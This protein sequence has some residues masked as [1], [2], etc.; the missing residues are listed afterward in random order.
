MIRLVASYWKFF[1]RGIGLKTVLSYGPPSA[2]AWV[3]FA[4]YL[5]LLDHGNSEAFWPTL[6]LGL[7]AIAIGSSIV[8]WLV[9]TI[10][11]PL[12]KITEATHPS[13]GEGRHLL[14]GP[15]LPAA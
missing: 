13:P 8:L 15:L 7:A 1:F 6:W 10:V 9:L 12:H 4:L 2:V 14:R 3:F 5:R 11:P